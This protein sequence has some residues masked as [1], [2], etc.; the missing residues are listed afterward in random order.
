MKS[1]FV[2]LT[3]CWT[4]IWIA[5]NLLQRIEKKNDKGLI[6]IKCTCNVCI[7]PF[8][9]HD[10]LAIL[11][12]TTTKTIKRQSQSQ[13]IIKTVIFASRYIWKKSKCS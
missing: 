9:E 6:K 13:Q 4:N 7:I 5:N 12:T 11:A 1:V 2:T 10:F 8:A 3:Q